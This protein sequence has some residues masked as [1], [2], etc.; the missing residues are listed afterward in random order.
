MPVVEEEM[1][2]LTEEDMNAGWGEAYEREFSYTTEALA[3]SAEEV[4]GK[5][6][7]QRECEL[8]IESLRVELDD[9]E[10]DMDHEL[11]RELEVTERLRRTSR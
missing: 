9:L 5:K 10:T 3:M 11:T 7:Q 6:L 2:K 8:Q 4:A 1:E